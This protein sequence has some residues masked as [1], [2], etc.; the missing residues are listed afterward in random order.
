MKYRKNVVI[1]IVVLALFVLTL[2]LLSLIPAT[3]E[4]KSYYN[5]KITWVDYTYV[6]LRSEPDQRSTSIC[7]IQEGEYVTLTGRM[8]Q[9]PLSIEDLD[10][11]N[12]VEVTYSDG[13]E[14]FTGWVVYRAVNL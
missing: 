3:T 14:V 4:Y 8:A 6:N 1:A 7:Q 9:N 5:G 13:N 2:F 10:T 11:N 12:W